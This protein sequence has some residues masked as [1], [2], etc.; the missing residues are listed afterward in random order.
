MTQER[1]ITLRIHDQF[2]WRCGKNAIT[3]HHA[4][5]KFMKPICN[6]QIPFCK[7]CHNEFHN[8]HSIL[9]GEKNK[10]KKEVGRLHKK[11]T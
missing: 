4:I 7:E 6:I 11:F 2:C 5:P 8:L 1:K 10:L 3:N 9:V